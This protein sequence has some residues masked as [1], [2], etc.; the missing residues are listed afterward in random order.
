MNETVKKI[1]DL[2]FA[3][4]VINNETDALHEELM[5]NCQEHY[6]DLIAR[7]LTEDEAIHEVVQSLKGMEEV[8]DRYPAADTREKPAGREIDGDL[9]TL[10]TPEKGKFKLDGIRRIL[11]ETVSDDIRVVNSADSELHLHYEGEN[12]YTTT[13][14]VGDTLKIGLKKLATAG[15]TAGKAGHTWRDVFSRYE[16]GSFS[17]NLKALGNM[18]QGTLENVSDFGGGTLTVEVPD[19][20]MFALEVNSRGGDLEVAMSGLTELKMNSTGGD[21]NARLPLGDRPCEITLN[22]TGGDINLTGSA[23]RL[24]ANTM[25][26]DVRVRGD[27][28][29]AMLKSVSGDAELNGSACRLNAVS[30]SGDVTVNT[31]NTG[32]QML[33]MNTVSGDV[34]LKLPDGIPVHAVFGIAGGNI[35]NRHPDLPDAKITAM[36][37]SVSGDIEVL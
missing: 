2:L 25:S 6:A 11:V 3:N 19:G 20:A 18:I 37:K 27:Y 33:T 17:F 23:D 16:D 8:I 32:D 24:K 14:N 21:V 5:N 29:S 31:E 30:V 28:G 1:V 15:E 35:E 26:G 10:E 22:S 36:L 7:G 12:R 34:K 4:T 13:E 9:I